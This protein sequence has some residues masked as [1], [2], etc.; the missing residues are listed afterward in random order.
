MHLASPP[1]EVSPTGAHP[2]ANSLSVSGVLRL[3]FIQP[4]LPPE[5]AVHVENLGT[6]LEDRVISEDSRGLSRPRSMALNSC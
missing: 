5:M 6:Q 3:V 4:T 1:P 2:I